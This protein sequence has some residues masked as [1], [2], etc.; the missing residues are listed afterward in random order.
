MITPVEQLIKIM[1]QVD[2]EAPH[3]KP[4]MFHPRNTP[5]QLEGDRYGKLIVAYHE[6]QLELYLDGLALQASN[7]IMQESDPAEVLTKFI[8]KM[9]ARVFAYMNTAL[10]QEINDNYGVPPSGRPDL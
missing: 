4:N 9:E 5:I 2:R 8:R 6:K 7:A 3:L 10:A 1:R